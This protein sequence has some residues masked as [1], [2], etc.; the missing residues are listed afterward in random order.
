MS[1]RIDQFCENL[2]VKLTTI[3]NNIQSLKSKID[4]KAK[5]AEQD[6]RV[7][8]DSVKKRVEQDRSKVEA[9]QNELKKW[10]DEYRAVTKEK[11]ADWKA[12]GE[13]IKLRSRAEI[14]ERYAKATAVIAAAAVDEAEQAAL[15]AWLARRDAN[16]DVRAG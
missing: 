16:G 13:R 15:E 1:E 12:S 7:H 10:L 4:A 11:I 3:D 2:R 5:T 8:L 6:V 9:A 14:A